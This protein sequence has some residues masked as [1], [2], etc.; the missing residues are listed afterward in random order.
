VAL[1]DAGEMLLQH[2]NAILGLVEQAHLDFC[3]YERRRA[4]A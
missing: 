4:V 2:A 1:T 3:A